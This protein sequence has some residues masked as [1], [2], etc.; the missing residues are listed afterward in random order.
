M[1]AHQP[2]PLGQVVHHTKHTGLLLE[3]LLPPGTLFGDK[4]ENIAKGTTDPSVDCFLVAAYKLSSVTISTRFHR[5]QPE[6][7]FLIESQQHE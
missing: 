5:H 6:S 4:V 7:Q 3:Q 2:V 1:L